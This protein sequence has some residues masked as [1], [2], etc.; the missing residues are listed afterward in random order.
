[1]GN[2]PRRVKWKVVLKFVE[3]RLQIRDKTIK[4]VLMVVTSPVHAAQYHWIT[5][6]VITSPVY[7]ILE[8]EIN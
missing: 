7:V 8:Y 1:M 3:L 4:P 6:E 2:V 5:W